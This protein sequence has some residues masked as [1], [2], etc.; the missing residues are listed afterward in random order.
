VH[1]LPGEVVGREVSG[2]LTGGAYSLSTRKGGVLPRKLLVSE[3]KFVAQ[4]IH[5]RVF[6][7][8]G[9]PRVSPLSAEMKTPR[10]PKVKPMKAGASLLRTSNPVYIQGK[11]FAPVAPGALLFPKGAPAKVVHKAGGRAVAR[12]PY[13]LTKT[14]KWKL[15]KGRWPR[16]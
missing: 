13:R 15:Y 12:V 9:M 3:K 1:G 10:P 14:G 5:P 2:G 7:E 11:G 4:V 16:K 8:A 6:D